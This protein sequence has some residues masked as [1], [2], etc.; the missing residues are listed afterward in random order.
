MPLSLSHSL[1]SYFTLSFFSIL[2]SLS[3]SLSHS[4]PPSLLTPPLSSSDLSPFSPARGGNGVHY[5]TETDSFSDIIS[6]TINGEN[7]PAYWELYT[8][9]GIKRIYGNTVDSRVK[10]KSGTRSWALNRA[11]DLAGNY[12]DYKYDQL[13]FDEYVIS[14]ILYTANDANSGVGSLSPYSSKVAFR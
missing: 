5:R 11:I 1:P 8:S 3:S 9:A 12:I 10:T 6:Y 13:T 14:E 7:E 4:I 2:F